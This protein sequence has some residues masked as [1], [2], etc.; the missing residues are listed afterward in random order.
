MTRNKISVCY[1]DGIG[2]EIM[3]SVLK[4]IQA[5]KVTLAMDVVEIGGTLFDKGF[6]SGITDESWQTLYNNKIIFKAPITTPQG[7]GMKSINVTLRKKFGLYA[8]IRPVISYAPFVQSHFPKTNLVIVR[9]NEEGLYA[10][11]EYRITKEVYE[12]LRLVSRTGA[13]KIIDFAFDYAVKNKRSNVTCMVKDNILKFS[14]G[15]FHKVFDQIKTSYP[16]IKTNQMI[17][18]IG[19]AKVANNPES[20]DIIVTQN[21][22][23][24]IISD[25]AAE[26]AGSIGMCGSANIGDDF[27]MFEAVHGSAPDLAGKNIANPSGLLN[28]AIIMLR[29]MKKYEVASKIENALN[30]TIEQGM[31]T[32]DLYNEEYSKAKLSTTEF[33]DAIIENLGKS[34]KI[35]PKAKKIYDEQDLEKRK[36]QLDDFSKITKIR[37]GIDIFVDLENYNTDDYY[38][39]IED[40]NQETLSEKLN[41]QGVSFKGLKIWPHIRKMKGNLSFLRMR[42][43]AKTKIAAREDLI[44]LLNKFAEL[45]IDV[46]KTQTLY[47]YDDELGFSRMQGE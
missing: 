16:E 10:G 9:E 44:E 15:I 23:G 28:G 36:L 30:K 31:H 12:T 21:L 1:G 38:Q 40:I 26:V 42:F 13:A 5:S 19:T 29:Y 22:Y 43:I 20:F 2:P 25:V 14:D 39:I 47:I 11:V 35:L 3:E 33:T 17:L 6:T 4:I 32:A 45:K 34:P 37:V 18:D 8:N 41:L 46:I 27:A 24:D 7:R